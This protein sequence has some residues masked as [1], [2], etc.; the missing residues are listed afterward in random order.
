[1]EPIPVDGGSDAAMNHGATGAGTDW[2]MEVGVGEA[3][4][5]RRQMLV[6]SG[7]GRAVG[8][9]LALLPLSLFR[10]IGAF[11]VFLIATLVFSTATL[12]LWQWVLPQL[13]RRQSMSRRAW[14]LGISL[15]TF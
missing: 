12:A 13:S 14:Q 2:A 6:I 15:V 11:F 9:R 8:L 4:P 3:R 5:L 7:M 1:M 10:S